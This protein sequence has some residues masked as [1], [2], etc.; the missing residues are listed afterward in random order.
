MLYVVVTHLNCYDLSTN[1]RLFYKEADK[2]NGCNLQTSELLDC[3]LIGVCAVIRSNA[4]FEQK[5][6]IGEQRKTHFALVKLLT[7]TN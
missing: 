5:A 2:I 1:N 3:A 6:T 7:T 4:V